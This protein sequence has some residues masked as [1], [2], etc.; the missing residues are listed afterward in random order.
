MKTLLGL[1]AIAVPYLDSLYQYAGSLPEGVLPP[2]AKL[3]IG[4]LGWA[5]ALY[6]RMVAKGPLVSPKK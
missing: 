5:L 6:G 2:Q 3:V 4:G 1:A